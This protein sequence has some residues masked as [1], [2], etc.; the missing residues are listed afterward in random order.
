MNKNILNTLKNIEIKINLLAELNINVIFK[1]ANFMMI[2]MKL[3]YNTLN[4][5]IIYYNAESTNARKN[6][7]DMKL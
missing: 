4:L 3:M 2:T 5:S 7:I 1:D 6:F